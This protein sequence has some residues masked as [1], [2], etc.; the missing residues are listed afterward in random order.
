[1]LPRRLVL[2]LLLTA[3]AL[4]QGSSLAIPLRILDTTP[5]PNALNV[6]RAGNVA[7]RFNQPVDVENFG[8]GDFEVFGRWSGLCP[9]ELRTIRGGTTLVF[10]P[11]TAFSA[12]EMVTWTF[13]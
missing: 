7:I 9:G 5:A 2:F 3:P 10:D 13:R 1:M 4:A 6:P 12:G 11:T 8:P